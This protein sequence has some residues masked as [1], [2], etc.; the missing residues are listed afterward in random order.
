MILSPTGRV[1]SVSYLTISFLIAKPPP[2][3][4]F[5]FGFATPEERVFQVFETTMLYMAS[6]IATSAV[7]LSVW[8]AASRAR[9]VL[10][11]H[12]V[13]ITTVLSGQFSYITSSSNARVPQISMSA[14]CCSLYLMVTQEMNPSTFM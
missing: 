12:C 8:A 4:L 7:R 9:R 2:A 13:H 6:S 1:I 3:S 5:F 11:F 14:R 10:A